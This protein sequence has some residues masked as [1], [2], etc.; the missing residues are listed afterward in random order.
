[1]SQQA[2]LFLLLQLRVLRFGFL[3][4]G[5][6]GVD[7]F[8]EGEEV[9]VGGDRTDAISSLGTRVGADG[10]LVPSSGPSQRKNSALDFLAECIVSVVGS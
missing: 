5:D 8:P 1:V 9:L 2:G 4:D 3:Q 6:V 10:D 7:V